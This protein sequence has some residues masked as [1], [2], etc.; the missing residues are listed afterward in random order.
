MELKIEGTQEEQFAVMKSAVIQIH[1]TL[2]GNGQDGLEKKFE[3][4]CTRIEAHIE[5]QEAVARERKDAA[6][7]SDTK[8]NW[9][10]AV[11]T[12]A[13]IAIGSLASVLALHHPA[14]AESILQNL[15]HS[16]TEFSELQQA[17]VP[18]IP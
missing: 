6:Q 11:L 2:K 5:T 9:L 15:S 13:A 10:I 12:L 14:R 16:N 17:R 7:R 8:M 18:Y 1:G 3:K 4:L